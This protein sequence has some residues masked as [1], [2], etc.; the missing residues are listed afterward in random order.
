[1]RLR[2]WLLLALLVGCKG[3][4]DAEGVRATATATATATAPPAAVVTTFDAAAAPAPPLAVVTTLDAALPSDTALPPGEAPS[5]ATGD[6][7]DP[8]RVALVARCASGHGPVAACAELVKRYDAGT[9][10][11]SAAQLLYDRACSGGNVVACRKL[12]WILLNYI[13]EEFTSEGRRLLDDMCMKRKDARSCLHLGN[14]DR[15][16]AE[17]VFGQH[18]ALTKYLERGCDLGDAE[19]CATVGAIYEKDGKE[20]DFAKA[21]AAFGKACSAGTADACTRAAKLAP[22]PDAA[23]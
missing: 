8:K 1:M 10:Y 20:Q 22:T 21:A 9:D 23:P 2:G 19:A 17:P 18:M 13:E 6:P 11:D 12:G 4:G 14:Y 3:G 7:S 16:Y 5:S 15:T